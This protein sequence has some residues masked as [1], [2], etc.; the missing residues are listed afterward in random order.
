MTALRGTLNYLPP[1]L[2]KIHINKGE[3]K[4]NPQK[5]DIYSLGMITL[6]LLLGE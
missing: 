1:E 5:A 6:K 4:C 3:C 2:W